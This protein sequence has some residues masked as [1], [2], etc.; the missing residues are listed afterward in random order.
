VKPAIA[1]RGQVFP[2]G[3][4]N[5]LPQWLLLKYLIKQEVILTQVASGCFRGFAGMTLKQ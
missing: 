5:A 2:K 3:W 1:W 4:G